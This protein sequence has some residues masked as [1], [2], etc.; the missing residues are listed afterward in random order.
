[1]AQRVS[2]AAVNARTTH[3]LLDQPAG[4]S[5]SVAMRLTRR[6]AASIT[7]ERL[8]S[9]A[10]GTGIVCGGL[11]NPD[12]CPVEPFTQT[13]RLSF[14]GI[15]PQLSLL[16]RPHL[17][18]VIRPELLIGHVESTVRAPGSGN[19]LPA[20]KAEIGF[21]AGLELRV[22]PAVKFPLELIAGGTARRLGPQHQELVLDGYT[23]FESWYSVRTIYAGAALAWRESTSATSRWHPRPRQRDR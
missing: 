13:G 3:D 17:D 20:D 2:V 7:L 15:G 14:V 6:L 5:V 21:S 1:L 16:G 18:L 22:I 12:R 11:I 19:V 9:D 10:S 8:R 23:P 4:V